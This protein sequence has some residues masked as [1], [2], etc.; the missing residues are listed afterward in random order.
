[1]CVFNIQNFKT[2]AKYFTS[3]LQRYKIISKLSKVATTYYQTYLF[4]RFVFLNIVCVLYLLKQKYSKIKLKIYFPFIN[5][6]I[7]NKHPNC[8]ISTYPSDYHH[9][10][11]FDFHL[12]IHLKNII[13][14]TENFKLI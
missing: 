14:L 3:A 1:M 2:K 13:Y 10:S 8:S 4:A 9:I 5:I 7:K 12:I 6:I 11:K